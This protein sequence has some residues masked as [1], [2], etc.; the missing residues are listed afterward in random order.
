MSTCYYCTIL[1]SNSQAVYKGSS[2][3]FPSATIGVIRTLK[4]SCRWH[5]ADLDHTSLKI[6]NIKQSKHQVSNSRLWQLHH[7]QVAHAVSPPQTSCVEHYPLTPCRDTYVPFQQLIRLS[8]FSYCLRLEATS[9]LYTLAIL[10][11]RAHNDQLECVD[12]C[13]DSCCNIFVLM[14]SVCLVRHLRLFSKY[15]D[16][17]DTF[18]EALATR[19]KYCKAIARGSMHIFDAL[20]SKDM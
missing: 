8:Q 14:D 17:P 12:W 4:S 7:W 10:T 3:L 6:H 19:Q 18:Q 13:N 15:H 9:Q 11:C 1:I 2:R 5:C 20:I 16:G